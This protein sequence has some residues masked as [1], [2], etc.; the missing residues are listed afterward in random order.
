MYWKTWELA[1]L[2]FREPEPQSGFVSQFIN[3]GLDSVWVDL[4]Q[5]DSCFMSMFCNYAH[6]LVP[7]IGSLDNFYAK[8]YEDGEICREIKT[9]GKGF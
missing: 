9:D 5:W 2:N 7:G 8:Q 1:F 6:P 4:F 3:A